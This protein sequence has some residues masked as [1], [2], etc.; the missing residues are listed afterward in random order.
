MI[1][2]FMN[3]HI[4]SVFGGEYRR[5]VKQNCFLSGDDINDYL[6]SNVI[7]SLLELPVWE[8]V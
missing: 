5:N 4:L 6:H 1:Y 8:R 7:H 3:M 2:A